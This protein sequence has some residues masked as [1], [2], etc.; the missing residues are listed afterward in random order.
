VNNK[1][2]TTTTRLDINPDATIQVQKL[3]GHFVEPLDREYIDVP[4]LEY[5]PDYDNR[6]KFRGHA[7]V[8]YR[9]DLTGYPVLGQGYLDEPY[10]EIN[11][12]FIYEQDVKSMNQYCRQHLQY[13]PII[14]K[15]CPLPFPIFNPGDRVHV[16]QEDTR[17]DHTY[18]T[19]G[20]TGI[21]V[22]GSSEGGMTAVRWDKE[23]LNMGFESLGVRS[24]CLRK[25]VKE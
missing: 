1:I 25:V 11:E 18:A 5:H 8:P 13:G 6:M 17:N 21:C 23:E 24:I 7:Y 4:L 10:I 19:V 16:V 12:V 20:E 22:K 15:K 3:T 2:F 14:L 9:E